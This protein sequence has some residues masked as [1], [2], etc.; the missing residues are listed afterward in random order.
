[1]GFQDI[2]DSHYA[3]VARYSQ[4]GSCGL[5]DRRAREMGIEVGVECSMN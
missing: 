4:T 2:L 3:S 1:M 5:A